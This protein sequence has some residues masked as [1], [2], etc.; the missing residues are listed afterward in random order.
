MT[1]R[2]YFLPLIMLLGGVAPALA[3]NLGGQAGGK[4]RYDDCLRLT[5]RDPAAALGLAGQWSQ[6]HGGIPAD[7]CAAVALVGLKRY[8][9]AATKLDALGRAPDVGALR[10]SLLD[11]AGNAWMLAGDAGHA[12]ASFQAALTLSANDADLYADLGRAE[13]MDKNW[14]GTE[15]DLNAALAIA[16]GRADF[17]V[18]RASAR[19]ALGKYP[20]ARAD[21][22]QAFALGVSGEP[23]E[24]ARRLQSALDEVENAKPPPSAKPAA[25]PAPKAAAK[26]PP[27]IPPAR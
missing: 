20:A 9:E 7:H 26:R 18:L 17:L 22:A 23:A 3:A 5:Q 1:K 16:P 19:Q 6:E 27:A 14:R 11:Q 8:A 12:I 24:S 25:K 4:Q 10:P 21:L 13:A 2:K 15:A